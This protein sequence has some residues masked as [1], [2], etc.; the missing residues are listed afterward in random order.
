MATP[1]KAIM[2]HP[3]DNNEAWINLAAH[4]KTIQN[5]HLRELFQN[6]PERGE[7]FT[8]EGANW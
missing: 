6:D 1:T 3:A 5:V 7:R 2:G 4:H 8:C